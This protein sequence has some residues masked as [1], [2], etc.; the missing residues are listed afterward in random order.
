[1]RL[2]NQTYIIAEAGVNHN[3]S[4]KYAEKLIL[5]AKKAGADA[6]K[7]QNFISE[8]LV[9]K[10]A[11]KAKYQIINTKKNSKQLQM[12]KKLELKKKSYF[13]LL[14]LCKKYKIDFITSVFDEESLDFVQQNLNYKFLKIPSGEINNF[15]LLDKINKNKRLLLSTGMSNLKN[16]AESINRIFKL[17]IYRVQKN[18][19][20]KINKFFLKKIIKRINVMHCVT[21]YPVE[22]LYA[23]LKAINYL[24]DKLKLDVGYSDHTRGI[25]APIVAVAYGAKVIEKHLTLDKKMPGPDHVASLDL[26][27]FKAMCIE[28][29][30]IEKMLGNGIKK[31]EKCEKKNIKIAKKSLVAK[32]LIKK[33]DILS[34][35]NVTAKRPFNG[36]S[37]DKI[38]MIINSKSKKNYLKD[39][40][41]K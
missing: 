34:L 27:E 11:P 15:I 5:G 6:I 20:V 3:G 8:N 33:G 16:I 29:R 30:N 10:G 41:I 25:S 9:T 23:N 22:N 19:N 14:K 37:P 24:K 12:L 7:F 36:T 2:F 4:M 39:D 38:D 32:K 13:K 17:K 18:N 21:D 28:I 40:L 31:I 1:M 35:D 26:N